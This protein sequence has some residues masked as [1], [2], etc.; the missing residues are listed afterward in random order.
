MYRNTVARQSP[1][2]KILMKL[3]LKHSA[4]LCAWFTFSLR[5]HETRR[6]PECEGYICLVFHTLDLFSSCLEALGDMLVNQSQVKGNENVSNVLPRY[7]RYCVVLARECECLNSCVLRLVHILPKVSTSTR[8]ENV[9][10]AI[11]L[12]Q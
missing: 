5:Q 4:L 10:Q 9:N 3:L 6:E 8:D 7:R 11:D 2:L 1:N 12:V